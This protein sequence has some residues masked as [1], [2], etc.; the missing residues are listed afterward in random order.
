MAARCGFG[1]SIRGPV[2]RI[3]LKK[4]SRFRGRPRR[5]C[6]RG[7]FLVASPPYAGV[8]A[9][10]GISLASFLRFWAVAARWNSSLAPF[11]LVVAI[12][13]I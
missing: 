8:G 13:P 7:R 5:D 11:G 1:T 6:R 12:D 4:S 10:I 9:V 3:S 2:W